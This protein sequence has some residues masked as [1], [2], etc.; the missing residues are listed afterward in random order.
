MRLRISRS[1]LGLPL[2]LAILVA[3]SFVGASEITVDATNE[4]EGP[5]TIQVVEGIGPDS[6]PY[7]SPHTLAGGEERSVELAVPGGDWA[8]TVNGGELLGSLDAG[9]RRGRLPVTLILSNSGP[10]WQAP[11]DW[12]GIDP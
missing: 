7:G 11:Q 5:M 12:A 1:I 9:S 8:V 6:M 2:V 4:T 3:C 10:Q